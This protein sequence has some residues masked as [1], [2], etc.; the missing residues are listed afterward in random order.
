MR[1]LHL[2]DDMTEL[3]HWQI[4][5]GVSIDPGEHLII[6]ADDDG[7]QGALHTNYQLSKSGE[8]IAIVDKD[9]KTIIDSIIFDVQLDDVSVGRFPDGGETWGY[10]QAATPGFAN[11]QH[12]P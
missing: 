12:R 3:T 1:V 11:R 2:T 8:T 6:Y 10:H 5:A 9:G 7:T 4:A